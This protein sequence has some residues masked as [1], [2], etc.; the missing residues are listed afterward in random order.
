M[1][2]YIHTYTYV[3]IYIYIYIYIYTSLSICSTPAFKIHPTPMIGRQHFNIFYVKLIVFA[4]AILLR[5]LKEL[6]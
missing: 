2:I 4:T 3:Y 6:I 1:C 5:S